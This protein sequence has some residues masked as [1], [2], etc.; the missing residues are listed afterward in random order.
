MLLIPVAVMA[1]GEAI[2]FVRVQSKSTLQVPLPLAIVQAVAWG[3]RDPERNLAITEQFPV[4][5]P[6]V[7][8]LPE[9][10]PGQE[11]PTEEMKL[12]CGVPGVGVKVK[13][14]LDP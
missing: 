10:D 7:Y 9:S 4:I 2:E 8:V 3:A 14:V 13:L 12:C 6:V 1:V 11:P 5:D